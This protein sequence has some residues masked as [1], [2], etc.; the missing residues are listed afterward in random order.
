MHCPRVRLTWCVPPA[1]TRSTWRRPMID[2]PQVVLAASVRE[3]SHHL[4]RYVADHG[5]VRLRATILHPADALDED[6]DVFV[7]D[8]CTSFLSRRFVDELQHRGRAVVGVF[9]PDDPTGKDELVQCG[10]DTLVPADAFP[11]EFVAAIN[12]AAPSRQ[13]FA[14]P[15]ADAV[16][17]AGGEP[18]AALV[19]DVAAS[20]STSVVA[21]GSAGGG[22]GSTELATA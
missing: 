22:A 7:G 13:P 6:H 14:V 3:W 8:D 10:V 9:D 20:P 15:D 21:V 16:T 19:K 5:G 11:E 2:E 17:V 1:R 4:H 18:G 12:A